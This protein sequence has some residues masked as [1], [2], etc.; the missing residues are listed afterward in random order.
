M[1]HSK[2]RALSLALLGL[3]ALLAWAGGRVEAGD[4]KTG[5][6]D[7]EASLEPA[8]AGPGGTAVLRV[9][10]TLLDDTHHI[11]A[12]GEQ[13]MKVVPIPTPGVTLDMAAL[14]ITAPHDFEDEYGDAY[15]VW[16]HGFEVSV[17]V[18]ISADAPADAKVGLAFTY[19]GCLTGIGC[20][21]PIRD[22]E[23]AVVLGAAPAAGAAAADGPLLT[24]EQ[25]VK[26]EEG[27]ASLR[28]DEAAGEAVVRFEPTFG[29][30]FYGPEDT[31]G[32][33][34]VSVDPQPTDGLTWKAFALPAAEKIEGPYEVRIPFERSSDT[35]EVR[36]KIGWAGCEGDELTGRCNPPRKAVLKAR[37][38]PA[39]AGGAGAGAPP[40]KGAAPAPGVAAAPEG[41]PKLVGGAA[42]TSGGQVA[43]AYDAAKQQVTV[44]FT[45]DPGFHMYGPGSTE[46]EPVVVTPVEAQGVT[47]GQVAMPPMDVIRFPYAVTIPLTRAATVTQLEVRVGFAAC[48]DQGMC[49]PPE[50]DLPLR[51]VW[52]TAGEGT[53]GETTPADTTPAPA[54]GPAK[55]QPGEVDVAFEYVEAEGADLNAQAQTP[56]DSGFSLWRLLLIFLGGMGLAFTP[57]VLPIIP[58]TV[59]VIT[60]GQADIPK[61]RLTALLL[62]YVGG[63][64][65][66]FAAMGVIAALAGGAVSGAFT[67]AWVIGGIVVVFLVLAASM[68]GIFE[69]QPPAWMMNLQGGAQK[70]SGSIV[71][72]FLFGCLGAVIASP[73]TGPAI[74]G[75]LVETAKSG[76]A[77]FGF[78]MFFAMGLGMGAV[79]FAA[80]ALNFAMRPG[81]W[82]VWVRYVFGMLLFGAALWYAKDLQFM[83]RGLMLALGLFGCGLAA[84]GVWWHLTTKEG[85]ASRPALI[86]GAQVAGMFLVILGAVA[87]FTRPPERELNWIY[88]RDRAHLI[89]LVEEAKQEGR[90]AI[91][92]FW[93]KWCHYCKEYDKLIGNDPELARMFGYAKLIK[94]DL[95]EDAER[96][97]LRHAVG[98][99][100]T[101]Q[102]YMVFLDKQGRIVRGADI[103]RWYGFDDGP[104]ELMRRL[105]LILPKNVLE[106]AALSR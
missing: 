20:Y 37:W 29:W 7:L 87:W 3:L 79:F 81:P 17:P 52:G 68:I 84:F 89:A 12:K 15:Q 88:V 103:T 99:E 5:R 36:I 63:L 98:L 96:W 74:A 26:E 78:A 95:T 105:R 53:P 35:A 10:A 102:P 66:T 100:A 67:S 75:L 90:P 28:V 24:V 58:I 47:W 54:D 97:D 94:V 43:M 14:K 9:K 11:Y 64:A 62:T 13:A 92:D 41:A 73:C 49:N 50:K 42:P 93:A 56:E 101:Q 82:M 59:S 44:T 76:D 6:I 34:T 106:K 57:C 2:T 19:Y 80:G 1:T 55:T 38:Q 39:A 69:L 33:V 8:D 91:V 46:G 25:P 48:D 70:R 16:E 72:A 4:K 83:T 77:L 21:P 85:E 60:G 40:A 18:T 30:H 27:G 86:R 104:A 31:S 71:G 23:A 45:P 32:S 65:L 51:L 22:H 61:K